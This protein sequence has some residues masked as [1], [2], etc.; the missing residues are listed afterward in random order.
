VPTKSQLRTELFAARRATS[1]AD[2]ARAALA[3]ARHVAAT[4]WLAPGK[5]IGLYASMP[6]EL[7]TAPLIALARARGCEIYLPRIT[8]M[9]ARRMAFVPFG[10]RGRYHAF[11]MH[12]PWSTEFFPARFLDTIFVA[13]VGFDA[14]GGRLGHG[15]G[16]Y[17]RALA[18]RNVRRHWRGPRLVGVAYAFQVVPQIPVT[19]TDIRMDFIVTDRG[20]DESLAHEDGPGLRGR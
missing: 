17:D 14:H 7:G 12:E 5:R 11:G 8:S 13:G 3:V 4:F 10:S 20:I 16:F 15:A 19:A 1:P 2:R 6:Q 9:R 18:F